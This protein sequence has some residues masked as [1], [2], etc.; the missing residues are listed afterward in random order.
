[1][2]LSDFRS[3][4]PNTPLPEDDHVLR[5]I[6]KKHVDNGVVNGSGF[7]RRPTEDAT[8]VN[9]MECFAPPV[10]N[11]VGEISK[12]RRIKY[13]RRGQLVRINVKHTM[14][15]VVENAKPTEIVLAF[16]HDPLQAISAGGGN[17][18]TTGKPADPSHA[19]IYGVPVE[20]TPEA[21]LIRD[22]FVAC[23]IE[24]F[25]VEPDR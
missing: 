7:M 10:P 2:P 5:Y 3:P 22:L 16:L 9:W 21:E 20:K 17:S 14:L 12:R 4:E 24:Q 11:Q 15:Y 18:T 19:L 6:G 25:A 23:I 8:S 13:E 1:L